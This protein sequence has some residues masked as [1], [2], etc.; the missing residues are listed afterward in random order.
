[1]NTPRRSGRFYLN[2]R[3]TAVYCALDL[4]TNNCRLLI[5]EPDAG[6]FT[7]IDAFSRIV[8]L[9]E[10]VSQTRR[11]SDSAMERTLEA[12]AVCRGK[13]RSR[14]V[15]RM[16]LVAT[17]ACRMAEN[18]PG[19]VTRIRHELGLNLEIISHKTE[20]RLA[21]AGCASLVDPTARSVI[22]F[23]IGG[24]S[25]EIAWL[26]GKIGSVEQDP[27]RLIR[28]WDSLPAGVVPLA[29]RYAGRMLEPTVFEEMVADVIQ[30]LETF[31]HRARPAMSGRDV[32]LLGAS[33]TVTTI[34][35]IFLDLPR[36]NRTRVDGMWMSNDEVEKV[37]GEV[38]MMSFAERL[39]HRCI[40]PERAELVLAGC[41]ILEAIRRTF[42]CERLRIA[43]RGLREGIL[44]SMMRK[45]NVW[46]AFR[47]NGQKNAPRSGAMK[48]KGRPAG[49]GRKRKTGNGRPR[50]ETNRRN[51]AQPQPVLPDVAPAAAQ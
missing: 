42:P 38:A 33:G 17:E 13:I 35:G 8:R 20:V 15:T 49:S 19:F 31:A 27:C 14:K 36:Y 9:G 21:T 16:R 23:D 29:E 2:R 10:G 4:G 40:G 22:I 28:A 1:M 51:G 12:L 45:D 39:A 48:Q 5:A 41:A 43:D 44:M 50:S 26:R 18:G 11:I 32:H 7:V 46:N 6:G 25:T 37:I 34:G 47:N 30:M 24:G 3:Q